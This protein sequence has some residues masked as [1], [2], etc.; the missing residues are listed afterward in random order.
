MNIF[1]RY[2][3]HYA[4]IEA[5]RE[6]L[7]L[8]FVGIGI[9]FILFFLAMTAPGFLM[10]ESTLAIYAIRNYLIFT[11]FLLCVVVA[12]FK[13]TIGLVPYS[14]AIVM[15]LVVLPHVANEVLSMPPLNYDDGISTLALAFSLLY[16]IFVSTV[17]LFVANKLTGAKL[18]FSDTGNLRGN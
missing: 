3:N 9:Y 12:N 4:E 10:P 11:I 14:V 6:P 16:A 18:Q 2:A 8:R 7:R 17:S 5:R 13:F 15:G 1:K